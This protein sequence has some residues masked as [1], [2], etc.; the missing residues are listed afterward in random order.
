MYLI[1]FTHF[2]R[3]KKMRNS[4]LRIRTNPGSIQQIQLNGTAF[5]QHVKLFQTVLCTV[6]VAMNSIRLT[7]RCNVMLSFTSSA[8]PDFQRQNFIKGIG[9]GI[10]RKKQ[11][12]TNQPSSSCGPKNKRYSSREAGCRKRTRNPHPNHRGHRQ[13]VHV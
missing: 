8:A 9:Y 11:H 4:L 3:R 12:P 6:S 10:K 5:H 13:T 1:F 7:T 2:F